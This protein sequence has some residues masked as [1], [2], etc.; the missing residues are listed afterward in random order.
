M[1]LA[2]ITVICYFGSKLLGCALLIKVKKSVMKKT[3][4]G[5]VLGFMALTCFAPS[6]NAAMP[7]ARGSVGLASM[8][9]SEHTARSYDTG[10]TVT[11]AVGLDRGQ[12][13][14]EAELGHQTS[15]VKNSDYEVS[16]TTCMA[17]FYYDIELPL[18][19]VKPF[20]TAGV[21]FANVVE[22]TGVEVDDRV[23]AWQIGAG[24]GFS[25]APFVT[26]DVQ[27]RH[28][29]TTD[30]ELAGAKKYSFGSNNVTIGLRITL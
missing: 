29:T 30:P 27:Y 5:I 24:A 12:Y 3:V 21:G 13:R 7:Y 28:L 2:L 20:V 22:D 1:R 11:G 4:T 25:V 26:C 23:L 16:M 15:G 8:G 19:P 14:V 10:Y 17:N 9:D 18:A 6:A